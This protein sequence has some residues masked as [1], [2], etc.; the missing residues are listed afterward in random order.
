MPFAAFCLPNNK[1]RSV[2]PPCMD[3]LDFGE[4]DEPEPELL[5]RRGRVGLFET[6]E[7]A[8][9]ALLRTARACKGQAWLTQFAFLVVECKG[10]RGL[11]REEAQ[12]DIRKVV[13]WAYSSG[14]TPSEIHDRAAR[15][16]DEPILAHGFAAEAD[17]RYHYDF[18]S[19][20]DDRRQDN[21]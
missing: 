16:M 12:R 19:G 1:N 18:V 2:D 21:A 14:L 8:E 9:D 20:V 13:E 5:M 17:T 15:A 10:R 11:L 3:P 7:D 4:G 6:R